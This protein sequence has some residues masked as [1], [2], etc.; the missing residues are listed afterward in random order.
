MQFYGTNDSVLSTNKFLGNKKSV[1][2]VGAGLKS[3]LTFQ[4]YMLKYL[5]M[6][7][8]VRDLFQNDNCYESNMFGYELVHGGLYYFCIL[9]IFLKLKKKM[10]SLRR[11]MAEYY[12]TCQK[13][14]KISLLYASFQCQKVSNSSCK[15]SKP[16]KPK[17]NK[18]NCL[19]TQMQISYLSFSKANTTI[20]QRS[21]S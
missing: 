21:L 12:K 16:W 17:L 6:E 13:K 14:K 3:V 10:I 4:R 20:H 9:I 19:R 5:Q 7:C 1:G 2:G 18:S 15:T 11:F 8:Y